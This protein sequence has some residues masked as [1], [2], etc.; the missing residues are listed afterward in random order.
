MK[1]LVS[2]TLL[3]T[4]KNGVSMN[5]EIYSVSTRVSDAKIQAG[6]ITKSGK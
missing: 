6:I 5:I 3:N 2:P 1:T 4:K